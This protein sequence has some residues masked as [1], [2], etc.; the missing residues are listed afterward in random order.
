MQGL[1]EFEDGRLSSTWEPLSHRCV[2]L[3]CAIQRISMLISGWHECQFGHHIIKVLRIS[4]FTQKISNF[5]LFTGFRTSSRSGDVQ[6]HR[7]ATCSFE[8]KK[9]PC[10]L[11]MLLWTLNHY[12][13][14]VPVLS[15]TSK[16][17]SPVGGM[18][19]IFSFLWG[20]STFYLC[21]TSRLYFELCSDSPLSPFFSNPQCEK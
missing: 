7:Y 12:L 8:K 9:T 3:I 21:H 2:L 1:C 20:F 18:A 6:D 11:F 4:N 10:P 13:T 17:K 16:I 14:D 5:V 19:S 15:M